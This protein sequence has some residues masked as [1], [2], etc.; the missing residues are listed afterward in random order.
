MKVSATFGAAFLALTA[1]AS[2]GESSAPAP[3]AGGYSVVARIPGPAD[4]PGWDY[5]SIDPKEERLYL[6]TDGVLA[7][8]IVSHHV[9]RNFVAGLAGKTVHGVIPL[10]DGEGAAADATDRR[11][12]FFSMR[13][14]RIQ[15]SV[16]TGGPAGRQYWH[17]PD[18][19]LSEPKTGMLIAVNGDTGDL[20]LI[21]LARRKIIG[22]IHIGGKLEFAA[23]GDD[24]TVYVNAA[25]RNAL[26]VVDVAHRK[27]VKLIPLAGC[28][29][30]TGLAFDHAY[31]LA[32]SV[33]D[34]GTV[35]VVSTARARTVSVAKVGTGAD[36]V[37]YDGRRHKAFISS[38][39]L[40]TLSIL[41]VSA[42]GRITVTQTLQVGV[43]TRLGAVDPRTGVVYLPAARF[44]PPAPPMKLPGLPLLPG[45][46]PG[47]FHFL[48][49]APFH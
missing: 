22:R 3:P 48:V 45:I 12:T 10:T 19:L 11:V 2:A 8:D 5:A 9:I 39:D 21:D 37:M 14:G 42:A 35:A 32:I 27:L 44:G 36:A 23:A 34:N 25:S 38:G 18:A 29:D 47:T 30:P 31:R 17:D 41:A 43:G 40:G 20:V 4:I 46:N 16:S 13:N 7:L 15:G 24:G 6:A 26:A 28:K 33:C 49:I 1:L